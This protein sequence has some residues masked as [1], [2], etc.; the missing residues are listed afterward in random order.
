MTMLDVY[1]S[2]KFHIAGSTDG[3]SVV[4]RVRGRWAAEL[5]V[6]GDQSGPS[7]PAAR[8]DLWVNPV[9]RAAVSEFVR[10]VGEIPTAELAFHTQRPWDEESRLVWGPM[11][12]AVVDELLGDAGVDGFLLTSDEGY[13]VGYWR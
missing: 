4:D 2:G 8:V 6:G 9:A 12:G 5:E 7:H 3:L 13:C 1:H 10:F 11:S